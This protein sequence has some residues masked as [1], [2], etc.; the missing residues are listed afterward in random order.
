MAYRDAPFAAPKRSSGDGVVDEMVRQFAD[1]HAFVRE[2][3]QNAI[4]AGATRIEIGI[5][6]RGDGTITTT[7]DDDGAGMTR[8][9]IEGPLLTLFSSSKEDDP[10]KIGKYGVGFVSIFATEPDQVEVFTWRPEGAWRVR[11]FG[12]HT[13][14]LETEALQSGHGTIVSLVHRIG[15]DAAEEYVVRVTTALER[16]CRHAHV[17]I[18]L[19]IDGARRVINQPLALD[20]LVVHAAQVGAERIVVGAG[21]SFAGFY[22]RGL[23]LYETDFEPELEARFGIGFKIDSPTLGHTISRDNVKRDAAFRRLLERVQIIVKGPLRDAMYARFAEAASAHDAATCNTLLSILDDADPKRLVVPLLRGVVSISKAL[24]ASSI[25]VAKGPS[26]IVDALERRSLPVVIGFEFA[27][28]LRRFTKKTVSSDTDAWALAIPVDREDD[29]LLIAL[30]KALREVG[31]S[32]ARVR[33]GSFMGARAAEMFRWVIAQDGLCEASQ[34]RV[35]GSSDA[36]LFLN[37]DDPAVR[38]ARRKPEVEVAAHL[39]ARLVLLEAGALPKS[40]VDKLLEVAC[41]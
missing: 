15:A 2:L 10:D 39:V 16:W 25:V 37:V 9:T 38:L 22:N 7:V 24:E 35:K 3:V 21:V 1:R 33:F 36:T 41:G 18:A 12:D 14:E 4:D 26:P 34:I 27:P 13:F 19:S 20:A 8:A 28:I 6:R 40:A 23:T 17:P 5:S 30:G 31:T 11:L 32:L 29:P